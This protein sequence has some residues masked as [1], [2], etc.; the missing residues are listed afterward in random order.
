M[1]FPSNK[2]QIQANLLDVRSLDGESN[3][4]IK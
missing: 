1:D 4:K 2:K 3:S